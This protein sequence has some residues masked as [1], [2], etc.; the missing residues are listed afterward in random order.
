MPSD[1]G[2]A[3]FFGVSV[4]QALPPEMREGRSLQ[5]MLRLLLRKRIYGDHPASIYG[6]ASSLAHVMYSS[7]TSIRKDRAAFTCTDLHTHRTVGHPSRTAYSREPTLAPA[8]FM[9][10]PLIILHFRRAHD[11]I[12]VTIC[13]TLHAQ[14][15]RL[16]PTGRPAPSHTP[17]EV[18]GGDVQGTRTVERRL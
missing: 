6:W 3:L 15:R 14:R 7:T 17:R 8:S 13:R 4:A 12:A 9:P 16:N 11:R 1:P 10:P 5:G 18:T 2:R